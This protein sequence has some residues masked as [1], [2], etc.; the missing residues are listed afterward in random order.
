MFFG[1]WWQAIVFGIVTTVGMLVV[2]AAFAKAWKKF[3]G[4]ETQKQSCDSHH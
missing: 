4:N 1:T 2:S 3:E